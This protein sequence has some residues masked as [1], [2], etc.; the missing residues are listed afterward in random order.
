[1]ARRSTDVYLPPAIFK[2]VDSKNIGAIT[3]NSGTSPSSVVYAL[4][5]VAKVITGYSLDRICHSQFHGDGCV[6]KSLI[7][8]NRYQSWKTFSNRLS[9]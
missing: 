3:D 8:I 1:M 2:A 5:K 6:D 7:N 9:D 4:S